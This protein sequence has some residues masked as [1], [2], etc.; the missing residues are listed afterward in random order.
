MGSLVIILLTSYNIWRKGYTKDS[1]WQTILND[2]Y[3]WWFAFTCHRYAS[4]RFV[5]VLS[6]KSCQIIWTHFKD[7]CCISLVL[8]LKQSHLVVILYNNWRN[9]NDLGFLSADQLNDICLIRFAFRPVRDSS[10]RLFSVL[11]TNYGTIWKYNH[12]MGIVLLQIH[13]AHHTKKWYM[14]TR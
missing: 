2:A 11:S 1:C 9:Q 7:I 6:T 14:M 10:F 3:L 4:F 8:L 13:S 12:W 5:A